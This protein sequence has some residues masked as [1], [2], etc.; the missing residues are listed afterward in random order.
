MWMMIL[1]MSG[2][3]V[4]YILLTVVLWKWLKDRKLQVW[5]KLVVGLVYGGCSVLST[6][7]AVDYSHMLLNIRDLGPLSAGLFF[8][9][10]SGILAGLI[11]GIER[12]IAGTY[13]E[14]GSYTRIACSVSTCLAGFLAAVLRIWLLKHK[15]PSCI[16]SLI[17]GAVMEVFHMYVVFI[18]HRDDM[19]MAYYVVNICSGPMILFT[20]LGLAGS[21]MVLRML[22][23]EWTNPFRRVAKEQISVSRRFQFWLFLVTTLILG[24]NLVFA[25]VM[26]TQSAVQNA[27]DTLDNAADDI[28]ISYENNPE[29]VKQNGLHIHVGREGSFDVVLDG[30]TVV[31]GAHTGAELSGEEMQAIREAAHETFFSASMFGT[32]CFCQLEK[33]GS[34]VDLLVQLPASEVYADRD[35]QMYEIAF[36]DILLFAVIYILIS[37]LV[38]QI[39]V[40][41]LS[42]V[43]ASLTRITGGDLNEVVNVRGSSEFASLSDDINQTVDTLK[44]YI[45][46]AEKRIEQEL[47][48]ARVIQDSALP[49]NFAFPRDDFRIYATMTPAREVGGDFYDFFFVDQHKLA[50]VIADVSGKG[51]PAALFMM[52]AKTAVRGLAESGREP[53]EILYR[54]NNLLCEGNDAEMFVTVWL[55]IIDLETGLMRCANAGHEYPVLMRAGG[56]YELLKDRHGLALAAMEKMKYKE[57]ELQLSPGDRLFVYT[58]GVPEAIDSETI[59]YGTGRMIRV[60]NETKDESLETALTAVKKD[61][62]CYVGDLDPFDDV[63]MLNFTYA[64]PGKEAGGMSTLAVEAK[65]ENLPRVISFVDEILEESGCSVKTQMQI[66]MAVEEIFVNIASYA[67]APG[68]GD[69]VI[70]MKTGEEGIIIEFRDRGKPFDPMAKA[71]PDVTLSAEERQIGGLGI[72]MV[73]KSMDEVSYRYENGENILTIRKKPA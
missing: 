61:L 62:D 3:T 29:L 53:A 15:K 14:I 72:F 49:K 7:F 43:N 56:E 17:L 25:Q 57:Y 6:H 26:Q 19:A 47:E 12:Y 73:K 13:W 60:L 48:F 35:L 70:T 63:T 37:L 5:Q 68:T 38:Q 10:F 33:L 55:G 65:K 22:T 27:R 42:L 28:R 16:F 32:E 41:N 36:A 8:D 18:T 54:A 34:N 24:F 52:R 39:V 30:K 40:N 71:D 20:G 11:G 21:S 67:Y 59:Q 2:I 4:L 44:G 66:D 58:D 64:G 31:D 69:A 50:I 1:K 9:P 45:E 51:I 23:G 46:A